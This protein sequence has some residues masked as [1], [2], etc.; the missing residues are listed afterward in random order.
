MNFLEKDVKNCKKIYSK[1]SEKK[2]NKLLKKQ[3]ELNLSNNLRSTLQKIRQ[4]GGSNTD[5]L[6]K[7]I[8]EIASL[9]IGHPIEMKVK[10]A[11]ENESYIDGKISKN[12]YLKSGSGEKKKKEITIEYEN[13]NKRSYTLDNLV[14]KNQKEIFIF[15]KSVELKSK[16]ME[17]RREKEE[18][19]A[20]EQKAKEETRLAKQEAERLSKLQGEVLETNKVLERLAKEF[21]NEN[22][23]SAHKH[24]HF[25]LE[26]WA[27]KVKDMNF[28]KDQIYILTHNNYEKFLN[29]GKL[30]EN[31]IIYMILRDIIINSIIISLENNKEEIMLKIYQEFYNEEINNDSINCESNI[32]SDIKN[33]YYSLASKTKKN[34]CDLNK[35][36]LIN[37]YQIFKSIEERGEI[38][39]N[40]RELDNIYNDSTNSHSNED[41]S[42]LGNVET[43]DLLFM[44]RVVEKIFFSDVKIFENDK[45]LSEVMEEIQPILVQQMTSQQMP[46]Q[47]YPIIYS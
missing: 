13:G 17:L 27:N 5:K 21:Y 36:G 3:D 24:I 39:N 14:N 30:N 20:A 41:V 10:D 7:I 18:R 35:L 19:L 4:D 38:R 40:F 32:D 46:V 47:R 9:E 1:L 26:E 2:I 45:S 11:N 29:N 43:Y 16:N 23:D 37:V 31:N 42:K 34:I 28:G 12:P 22:K 8:S 44:A 15:D 25:L 6:L 33:I